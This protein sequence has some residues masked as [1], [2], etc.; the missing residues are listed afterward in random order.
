MRNHCYLNP[1]LI[2]CGLNVVIFAIYYFVVVVLRPLNHLP[3]N[4]NIQVPVNPEPVNSWSFFFFAWVVIILS[5]VFVGLLFAYLVNNST[6]TTNVRRLISIITTPTIGT[7]GLI[8][9]FIFIASLAILTGF[10]HD[11]VAFTSQWSAI[12]KGA[13]PWNL[14]ESIPVNAYG[15]LFNILALFFAIHP[16]APKLL[17]CLA[18]L[19]VSVYLIKILSRR[20]REEPLVML[21]GIFYV[22]INPFFW[23]TI[24]EYGLFDILPS[25]G[26]LIA[27]A[28]STKRRFYLSGLVLGIGVLFKYYPIV[29]LPL[30]MIDGRKLR[31][32]P[33]LSCIGT[34]I[35]GLLISVAVWGMST[36]SPILFA[37]ERESKVLSIFM[38][39]RGKASPLRL[40]TDQPNLDAYSTYAMVLFVTLVFFLVWITKVE[41]SLAAII[42]ILTALTFYKVGHSQF[43]TSIFLMVPFWYATSTLSETRKLKILLPIGLLLAWLIALQLVYNLFGGMWQKPWIYLRD[44]VGLPTFVIECWSVISVIHYGHKRELKNN[45]KAKIIV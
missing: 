21:A 45:Y 18:W 10:R 15:P 36:F 9:L 28:L 4:V 30:L 26:C 39:L 44:I 27:I 16:L 24:A 43:Y 40:F 8:L 12:L 5:L 11:Y 38:F 20:Y 3:I 2:L 19:G 41:I 1:L 14:E 23:L 32:S 22:F 42:G 7:A 13:D 25:I 17:F 29:L 37:S 6:A 31:F 33:A 34:I 35:S